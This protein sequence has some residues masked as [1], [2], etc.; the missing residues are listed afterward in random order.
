M[1]FRRIVVA[2]W[3]RAAAFT[4]V[5]RSDLFSTAGVLREIGREGKRVQSPS[6][7][8]GAYVRTWRSSRK[9]YRVRPSRRSNRAAITLD[10]RHECGLKWSVPAMSERRSGH[11]GEVCLIFFF[12][13]YRIRHCI[14]RIII[15]INNQIRVS[16]HVHRGQE[17]HGLN[18]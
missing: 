14:V 3:I 8:V 13:F 1:W 10:N 4:S 2:N 15:Q 17:L 9:M 7:V 18:R 16:N 5:G 6:V 12:K 11:L